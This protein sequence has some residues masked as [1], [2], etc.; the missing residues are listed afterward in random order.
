MP[1]PV[2]ALP[3]GSRSTMSTCSPMAASAV[4]RLIAV[5]VLPTPPFWLAIESTRGRTGSACTS[6]LPN[7]TTC[8]SAAFG[9]GWALLMVGIPLV[10]LT[11]P[12]TG[13]GITP[14]SPRLGAPNWREAANDNDRTLGTGLTG[15]F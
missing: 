13:Y 15:H 2:E 1:S 3:C 10:G 11:G 6:P 8:G 7:G 9:V 12:A 4:P 14:Q 5:V